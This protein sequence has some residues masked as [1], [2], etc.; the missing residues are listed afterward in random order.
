MFTLASGDDRV[1]LNQLVQQLV[2][3]KRLTPT[4]IRRIVNVAIETEEAG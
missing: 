4:E 3:E 2:R 1:R